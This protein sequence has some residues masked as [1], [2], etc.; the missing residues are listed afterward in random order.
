MR[1]QA[2]TAQSRR[3]LDYALSLPYTDI[4]A[5]VLNKI[6]SADGQYIASQTKRFSEVREEMRR[7]GGDFILSRDEWKEGQRR[8]HYRLIPAPL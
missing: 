5:P 3:I 6:G 8:T 1:T 7:R 4:P 2:L